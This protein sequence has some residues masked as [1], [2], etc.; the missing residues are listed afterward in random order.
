MLTFKCD[1]CGGEMTIHSSGN[2]VCP[3]CGSIQT[4]SDKELADY[5]EFRKNILQYLVAVAD[6][7]ET[8]TS[9]ESFWSFAETKNFTIKDGTPLGVRYIYE[10]KDDDISMY[11]ARENV[12]YHYPEAKRFW[13]KEALNKVT[14]IT[15]P[16]AGDKDL[17][18]CL[19]TFQGIYE[20]E[21]NSI[22]LVFRKSEDMYP[23]SMFGNLP[24]VHAAWI[25]S[26]IENICCL[27]KYNDVCHSG[28]TPDSIF[29]NPR[30]HEAAL[31]GNWHKANTLTLT[32]QVKDL[33]DMRSITTK[34]IG[35]MFNSIPDMFKSFLNDAPK[36]D[37]YSDFEYWDYVIERGL[38]GR[39][40]HKID[41][42]SIKP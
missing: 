39:H 14:S 24:Y 25:V 35:P 32:N 20:L 21:D 36:A 4:F 15:F 11:C 10:A 17:S 40:F 8:D 30:T 34:V 5:R 16:Q 41:T 38:G 26:R 3:Y 9:T 18:R 6:D 1:N 13:A 33:K 37:A 31:M 27:L 22:I 7:K 12:I 2:L 23:L 19:P 28:F 29:I 42:N